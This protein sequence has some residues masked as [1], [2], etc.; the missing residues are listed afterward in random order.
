MS[1]NVANVLVLPGDGIGPEIVTPTVEV[2]NRLCAKSDLAL[3]LEQGPV[4]QRA[5]GVHGAHGVPALVKAPAPPTAV[6]QK[7]VATV[8]REAG[9]ATSPALGTSGALARAKACAP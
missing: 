9:P 1:S 2:L 5:V 7:P 4:T 3:E 8:E 6:K